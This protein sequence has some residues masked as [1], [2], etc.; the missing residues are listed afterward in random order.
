MGSMIFCDPA[1]PVR[2]FTAAPQR[3]AATPR[4]RGRNETTVLMNER[5]GVNLRDGYPD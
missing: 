3:G 2:Y 4:G 1:L 5:G